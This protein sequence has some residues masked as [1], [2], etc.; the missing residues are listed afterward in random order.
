MQGKP[1]QQKIEK[2]DKAEQINLQKDLD[3]PSPVRG[4][5]I[6][7]GTKCLVNRGLEIRSR[8]TNHSTQVS[9]QKQHSQ[10][11]ENSGNYG[12]CNSFCC[13]AAVFST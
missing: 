7:A 10:L 9:N 5:K 1:K 12:M 3:L 4:H 6:P 11:K 13:R 2:P 8:R